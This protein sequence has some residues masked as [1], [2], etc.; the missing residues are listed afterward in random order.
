MERLVAAFKQVTIAYTVPIEWLNLVRL[1]LERYQFEL[2]ENLYFQDSILF[3][4]TLVFWRFFGLSSKI[5]T[6]FVDILFSLVYNCR[7][8]IVTFNSCRRNG[9]CRQV[10][11]TSDCGSDMRGF[12]SHQAP[13]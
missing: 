2:S 7:V 4:K 9:A 13:H 3:S 8:V 1:F 10:V 11:K 5:Y 12:E 6:F